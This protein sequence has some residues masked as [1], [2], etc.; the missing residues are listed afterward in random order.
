MLHFVFLSFQTHL[1][2]QFH[3]LFCLFYILNLNYNVNMNTL[4]FLSML[5]VATPIR[6]LCKISLIKI[7]SITNISSKI[8]YH[9]DNANPVTI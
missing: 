8:E 1:F 5:P 2:F 3:T 9:F 7:P 4:K 6:F